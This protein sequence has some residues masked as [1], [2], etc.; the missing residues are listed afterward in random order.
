MVHRSFNQGTARCRL[1]RRQLLQD[2]TDMC[3][4]AHTSEQILIQV[5]FDQ[6]WNYCASRNVCHSKVRRLPTPN[7][8]NKGRILH[9]GSDVLL[10][11]LRIL[12]KFIRRKWIISNRSREYHNYGT[13]L[14]ECRLELLRCLHWW[15]V[16]LESGCKSIRAK[17]WF[18]LDLA[19]DRFGSFSCSYYYWFSC[20]LVQEAEEGCS[21][22]WLRPRENALLSQYSDHECFVNE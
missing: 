15:I 18:Q 16:K 3:K 17:D 7:C 6:W 11:I 14:R 19:L 5:D 4:P 10:R 12:Y 20:V 13:N 8:I 9:L 1:L 2:S 21:A 22:R